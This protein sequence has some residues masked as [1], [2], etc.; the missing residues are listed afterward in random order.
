MLS[1][2][3]KAS[4][5]RQRAKIAAKAAEEKRLKK[6]GIH[7]DQL[8]EIKYQFKDLK[9]GRAKYLRE[10]KT[11]SSHNDNGR[12]NTDKKESL[13]YTGD[14]LLGIATMHKSNMVPVFDSQSAEDLAKMR[15]N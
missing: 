14:K 12:G 4:L 11:Y 13:M 10:T 9:Q 3:R 1:R 6:L 5:K 15:R 7:S 2:K 8:K